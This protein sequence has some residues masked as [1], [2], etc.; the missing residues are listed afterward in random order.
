MTN[1]TNT[2]VM[3]SILAA[4]S[5]YLFAAA[6]GY[7]NPNIQ[8]S[9]E[10]WPSVPA[11]QIRLL[12][13]L[14]ALISLPVMLLVSSQ[15]GKR[16]NYKTA[17]LIGTVL[18]LVGGVGP[19]FYAPSWNTVLAFRMIIGLGSG[20]FGI[21]TA[22][23][24]HTVP[25]EKR[26]RYLG[27]TGILSSLATTVISPITG[28]LAEISWRHPFLINFFVI[29]IAL[30][31]GAFLIE[32]DY[33]QHAKDNAETP[34]DA[35]F[36]W[37]SLVYIAIQFITTMT[38]Y[39]MLSGISTFMREQNLG[40]ASVAG[41]AISFYTLGGAMIGLILPKTQIWFGRRT[42]G[43][44]LLLGAIGQLIVIFAPHAM[45]A[46]L[47]A[48]ICGTGFIL[49]VNTFQLYNAK[50]AHPSKMA[51]GSTLLIASMQAGVF[52]SNYFISLSH[53]VIKASSEVMSSYW[54]NVAIY[55]ILA[56]FAI[57]GFLAPKVDKK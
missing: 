5:I 53:I 51:L 21:R 28:S 29:V 35:K 13:T 52:A 55:A 45:I 10:A 9:I 30:A 3:L 6:G 39:P 46:W 17:I 57:T 43:V 1:N 14:P 16:I 54:A 8:T 27:L 19:Y 50:I 37:M 31:V 44:A 48:F 7:M 24:I 11:D 33:E 4:M 25:K 15:I 38:M 56:V 23:L 41:L 18:I 47:G 26:A 32:P 20:F 42:Q 12:N 36:P 2:K 22:L 40:S 49:I 34:V